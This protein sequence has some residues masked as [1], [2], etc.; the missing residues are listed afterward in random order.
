M[1][2]LLTAGATVGLLLVSGSAQA[3]QP[4]A[5]VT[6][7]W[8]RLRRAHGRRVFRRSSRQLGAASSGLYTRDRPTKGSASSKSGRARQPGKGSMLNVSRPAVAELAGPKRPRP[9]FRD[10]QAHQLVLGDAI[11]VSP[12]QRRAM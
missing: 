11:A 5:A 10:L 12:R 9:R 2:K 4:R 3:R 6:N 7:G 1:T 8:G